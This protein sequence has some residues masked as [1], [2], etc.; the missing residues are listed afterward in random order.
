MN[1]DAQA[2][3]QWQSSK[4]HGP[5][6]GHDLHDKAIICEPSE[7]MSEGSRP[8]A[9][10]TIREAA[11]VEQAP[12]SVSFSHIADLI[13]KGEQVPNVREIPDTV[14]YGQESSSS[15]TSRK[16]PWEK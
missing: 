11:T 4:S 14:L 16:K 15:A 2:Y 7:S 3:D 8:V 1:V 12:Q 13:M 10:E 5:E 9:P 6:N